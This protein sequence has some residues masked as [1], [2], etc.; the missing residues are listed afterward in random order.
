MEALPQATRLKSGV[1]LMKRT[2]LLHLVSVAT[3]DVTQ[4]NQAFSLPVNMLLSL[5]SIE[6]DKNNFRATTRVALCYV[7]N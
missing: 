4:D 1:I 7:K 2:A 5:R 6:V 3:V